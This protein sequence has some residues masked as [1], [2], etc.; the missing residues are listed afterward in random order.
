VTTRRLLGL[1]LPL[2]VLVL[3]LTSSCAEATGTVTGGELLI[4]AGSGC[5]ATC[6]T[7]TWTCLYDNC[8]GPTGQASC[9]TSLGV[10]HL[11]ASQSGAMISGFVCGQTKESC[12]EGMTMGIPADAGGF[13][14]PIVLAGVAPASTVFYKAL[15]QASAT[16]DN[17]LC[18]G[19]P[20]F[21]C[22]MP[23][24]D[25]ITC[26]AN[27]APYTFTADDLVQISAW[28]QQGAQDN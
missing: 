22:N 26:H 8:F 18:S 28:I 12:W 10:C 20:A 21:D 16:G 6:A 11:E 17:P 5:A 9:S 27:S 7:P 19:N 15:H 2:L 4:E 13:F 23:C 24:G 14:P 25:P 3:G 1:V